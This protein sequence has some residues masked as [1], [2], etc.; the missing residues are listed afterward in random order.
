MLAFPPA[1]F[2]I[3]A[4]V[5][6]APMLI[7]LRVPCRKLELL[8]LW[9]AGLAF[10]TAGFA[11]ARHVTFLGTFLLGFYISL[12]FVLFCIS[13]RWL[14]FKKGIPLALAAPLAW[15]GLEY[16]RGVLLTGLPMLFLA[17]TQYTTLSVIQIA[18]LT[19]SA[20]VTFWLVAVNGVLADGVCCLWRL[21]SPR[22]P[23][24]V[25][26]LAL[27]VLALSVGAQAY[28]LYRLSTIV[29][30]RGPRIAVIQ[31]NI[32]Q[33]VKD[34]MTA[35]DMEDMFLTHVRMTRE[36][37]AAPEPPSLVIWPETMAPPHV[38]DAHNAVPENEWLDELQALQ[39]RSDLL[40]SAIASP[41]REMTIVHNS[42]FLLRRRGRGGTE[43]YDKIHLVPF[44]EYVPLRGLIGWIVGPMIPY[45]RGLDPGSRHALFEIDGWR[46]APT[47]CFEDAF[48]DLVADFGRGEQRMD[49]IVNVTNE[50]W[51]KD[52]AEL[53]QHLAIAVFRA[54]ECRVGFIRAANTGISAFVSPTGRILRR[55][56]VDGSDREVAGILLGFATTAQGRSPYLTVGELFGQVCAAAWLFCMVWQALP[57]IR[58]W[59][60][61]RGSRG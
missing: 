9:L 42:A 34:R 56:V 37:Q 16:I 18:D 24:R 49:F 43:R 8:I 58:G 39:R 35:R 2:S 3:L 46:F 44:G 51:F 10:G 55:L 29:T 15:A 27:G 45:E 25:L 53:D 28:G 5:A 41:T 33:D 23:V 1:G 11:W 4:W 26:A 60:R 22:R 61:R 57:G 40:V 6:L 31:A 13:A 19:G 54:V 52:G 20:G 36:A 48:P 32:P 17:H 14:A 30:R 59:L 7:A 50:G 12:Y 38:L 21:T 47:I